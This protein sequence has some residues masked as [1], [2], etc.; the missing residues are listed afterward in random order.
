MDTILSEYIDSIPQELRRVIDGYLVED[1]GG[2]IMGLFVVSL[3]MVC[4][5]RVVMLCMK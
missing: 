4:C 1:R 3:F 5:A 2:E